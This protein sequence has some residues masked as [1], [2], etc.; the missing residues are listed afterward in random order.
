M[1]S[2]KDRAIDAVLSNLNNGLKQM[3]QAKHEE[4]VK[5]LKQQIRDDI[6]RASEEL[7]SQLEKIAKQ[8]K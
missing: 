1:P 7:K 3:V 2:D 5:L 8:N 6:K 4:T